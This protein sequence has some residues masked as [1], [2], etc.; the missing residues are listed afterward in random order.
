M[1]KH[2]KGLIV[3]I[4]VIIIGI[5]M[6]A[7][8]DG[9]SDGSS[10]KEA[11]SQL[12]GTADDERIDGVKGGNPS[13]IPNITYEDAYAHF[14]GNPTWRYFDADDGSEVVEF[15]GDCTYNDDPAEVYIQF[16]L[17]DD[18]TFTMHY[19][20]LKVNGK[21]IET[22]EKDMFQLVYKPFSQYAEEVLEEPL[23]DE[24]EEQFYDWYLEILEEEE[25]YYE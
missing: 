12:Q 2:N 20:R 7:M 3:V 21:F 17:G 8:S 11:S 18:D 14:F 23:D 6:V 16:V 9:D 1:R 4:V 15:V 19:A 5:A 25:E 13:L 22:D 10:D 24:V